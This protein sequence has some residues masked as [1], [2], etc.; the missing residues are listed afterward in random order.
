[1]LVMLSWIDSVFSTTYW[2][3]IYINGKKKVS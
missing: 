1:M 3:T 2:Y